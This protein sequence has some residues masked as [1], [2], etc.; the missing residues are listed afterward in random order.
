M[1]ENRTAT[2]KAALQKFGL[3]TAAGAVGTGIGLILT[4]KPNSRGSRRDKGVGNL[5]DDLR[6]KLESVI[7]K[8]DDDGGGQSARRQTQNLSTKELTERRRARDQRRNQRRS[9]AR[10]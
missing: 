6:G 3:P 4:R 1:G 10:R 9:R 8:N 5:V 7:G 2:V